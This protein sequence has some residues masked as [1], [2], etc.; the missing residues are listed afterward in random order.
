[1]LLA[2]IG[3]FVP[4]ERATVTV[5]DGIY[6]RVG[7]SDCLVRGMSTFMAEMLETASIIRASELCSSASL[8]LHTFS[9]LVTLR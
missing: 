5:V 8:L 1:M 3:S 4:C 7:A 2:Q 6:A 9:G